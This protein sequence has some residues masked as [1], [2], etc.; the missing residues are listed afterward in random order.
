MAASMYDRPE[1]ALRTGSVARLGATPKA[2][3]SLIKDLISPE[4][5]GRPIDITDRTH[6]LRRMVDNGAVLSPAKFLGSI[7]RL[8]GKPFTLD[9]YQPMSPLYRALMPTNTTLGTGRQVGKSTNIAAR[10]LLTS[11]GIPN[12]KTLYVTPLYEQIRRFSNNY[13]R[14]FIN[15]SPLRSQWVSTVT[16]Q[17]VLQRSFRNGSLMLFS[18]ALLDAD[19]IRGVS[20][21]CVCI[22]EVQDMDPAHLPIINET[23]TASKQYGL[24]I[25]TGTHKSLSSALQGLWSES[26][27]AEWV[28]PCPHPGCKTENVPS[29]E[30]H[31]E[32]MIGPVH[33]HIG[34][35]YPGVVCRKCRRPIS[36]RFGMWRHR[37]KELRW[38]RAGY[39]IP[40][41]ILPL[42]Y[43]SQ[44]KWSQI[45][46][47]K[48]GAI[49]EAAFWNEVMG[50]AVDVGQ[51][52]VSES[53][54]KQAASLPW[55]NNPDRPNGEIKK[56]L[57]Q[58]AHKTLA[59]DWGGGGEKGTSFTALAVLGQTA[60]GKIDVLWGKRLMLGCDRIRE[61]KEIREWYTFFKC[62]YIAHDFTGA[63]EVAEAVLIQAGLQPKR[64][65]GIRLQRSGYQDIMVFH[66]PTSFNHHTFHTLD[67]ARSLN[68][69]CTAIRLGR[70]RFFQWDR[71]AKDQ[72]GLIGDFLAL[73]EANTELRL[74]GTLYTIVRDPMWPDDWAQ[75]VNLG[76]CLI[77]QLSDS[78]PNFAKLAGIKKLSQAQLH[79]AGDYQW[80]WDT[81]PGRAHFLGKP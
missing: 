79:A 8:D 7:L 74:G 62:E 44:E 54:L 36:P 50:E 3:N 2:V 58:Y 4:R 69:T 16:E 63:G 49:S 59:I 52:L 51:K 60:D 31:A 20:A 27:Q 71:L 29:R 15:Q 11:L 47:K 12:F 80:G 34:E 38:V 30:F 5:H 41:I 17:S 64:I 22:D 68:Y 66:E 73:T 53:E 23:L 78:W 25:F 32:A 14:P 61:A 55:Q 40:Q 37:Y 24:S 35:R 46:R 18:F 33:M 70:V 57:N 65:F 43:A 48:S 77:W 28:I 9:D 13:V 26:S 42:H 75:A 39:H 21:H 81:D 6:A 45:V 72:I 56:R 67:K 76:T 10:G 19:R 1:Q